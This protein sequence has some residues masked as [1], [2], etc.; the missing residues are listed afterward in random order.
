MVKTHRSLRT[1]NE[2]SSIN[3]I[4]MNKSGKELSIFFRIFINYSQMI[5]IIHS[6][7]LKWPFY[8]ASYLKI[9]GNIGSISSQLLSLECLIA[10]FDLSISAIYLKALMNIII[11]F[12]LIAIVIFLLKNFLMKNKNGNNQFIILFIVLSIMIQPNS[13][14]ETSDL[15]NCQRIQENSYLVKEMS[16]LCYTDAHF[17]WV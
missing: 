12:I 5:A 7:E 1:M 15:F 10:E 13:I 2:S 4:D 6:L 9:T 14:K 8:V 3:T 11:H 17:H 16:L